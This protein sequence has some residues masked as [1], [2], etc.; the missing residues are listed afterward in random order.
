MCILIIATAIIIN[1]QYYCYYLYH[2]HYHYHYEFHM[3][4]PLIVPLLLLL[5]DIIILYYIS[6]SSCTSSNQIYAF[7]NQKWYTYKM[8]L[9]VAT[10]L[11]ALVGSSGLPMPYGYLSQTTIY[12]R[13]PDL[14]PQHINSCR[15]NLSNF[16]EYTCMTLVKVYR[17]ILAIAMARHCLRD[18]RLRDMVWPASVFGTLWVLQGIQIHCTSH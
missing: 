16:T 4:H 9:R 11:K 13:I 10:T 6:H 18:C 3:P 5:F 12:T 15:C 7:I 2:W 14:I 1:C 8:H 17:D